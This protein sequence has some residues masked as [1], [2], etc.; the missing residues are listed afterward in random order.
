MINVLKSWDDL[1]ASIHSLLPV[2]CFH[3]DPF[4]NW[5]LAQIHRVCSALPKSA[6]ILDAG[7]SES[8]CSTL[9]YFYRTGFEQAEGIDL[10]ISFQDRLEQFVIMKS[11][12][13]LKPPF[14]LHKGDLMHTPFRRDTFDAVTCLSVIEHGVEIELFFREMCRVLKPGGLLYVSTDY[15][16]EKIRTEG[17]TA[18]GLDWTI[19]SK[20]EIQ[21]VIQAAIDE[22]LRIDDVAIPSAQV[23]IV[24]WS[25][26]EYTFISMVFQKSLP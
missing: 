8:Y 20:D 15:W 10:N 12:R 16:P 3:A 4:K 17:V 2:K 25:G 13:M 6:R 22:G 1:G 7:C 5:D 9:K 11:D 19:F 24:R 18:W 21:Q 26:K 23:P 14:R